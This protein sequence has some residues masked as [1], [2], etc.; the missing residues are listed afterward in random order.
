[1]LH[2]MI[3]YKIVYLIMY[4]GHVVTVNSFTIY[5]VIINSLVLSTCPTYYSFLENINCKYPS[6]YMFHYCH[7]FT[8]TVKRL[9]VSWQQAALLPKVL[10]MPIVCK[11]GMYLLSESKNRIKICDIS[12]KLGPRM[13]IKP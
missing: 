13:K 3:V 12:K 11:C 1:M 8:V 4:V 2:D 9:G 6:K 7:A 5:F 10:S